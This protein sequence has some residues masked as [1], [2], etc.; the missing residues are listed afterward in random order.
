MRFDYRLHLLF[1]GRLKEG[2]GIREISDATARDVGAEPFL[3][4]EHGRVVAYVDG[5]S[6]AA[7]TPPFGHDVELRSAEY[8]D[9]RPPSRP[10]FP[11][12]KVR[13]HGPRRHSIEAW[14]SLRVDMLEFIWEMKAAATFAG[15]TKLTGQGPVLCV[16]GDGG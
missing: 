4:Y 5:L 9:V 6:E 11:L 1:Q 15:S 7:T 2:Y 12:P 10:L 16:G 8:Q 3:R 14:E 13:D